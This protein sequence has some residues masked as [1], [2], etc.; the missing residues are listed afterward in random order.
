MTPRQLANI[1][2]AIAG[3]YDML[4]GYEDLTEEDQLRVRTAI[5]IGHVADRDLINAV[6]ISVLTYRYSVLM[7]ILGC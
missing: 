4:D 7:K 5:E 6:S 3:S 1:R 2:V